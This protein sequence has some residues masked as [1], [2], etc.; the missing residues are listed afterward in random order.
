[1]GRG[2]LARDAG[3]LAAFRQEAADRV[4]PL[5]APALRLLEVAELRLAAEAA[6]IASIAREEGQLVVRFAARLGRAEATRRLGEGAARV[7]RGL[8]RFVYVSSQAGGGPTPS[9]APL[10][11]AAEP[12]PLPGYGASKLAC[13][14]LLTAFSH[15]FD[16]RCWI[17]RFANVVG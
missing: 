9:G 1:M 13:E 14:A 17:Y 10:D 8:K 16:I 6:G 15:N 5:P 3:D 7:S 2:G 12:H 11:E 4:G